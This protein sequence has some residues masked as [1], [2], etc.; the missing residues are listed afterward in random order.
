MLKRR[1]L[2]LI[3]AVVLVFSVSV[4]AFAAV[5]PAETAEDTDGPAGPT[6]AELRELFPNVQLGDDGYIVTNTPA[7]VAEDELP[8]SV[9]AAGDPVVTYTASEE[10]GDTC[11]LAIYSDGSYSAYGLTSI[12][13]GTA[14]YTTVTGGAKIYWNNFSVYYSMS[15]IIYYTTSTSGLTTISKMTDPTVSYIG[16]PLNPHPASM[17]VISRQIV[18]STQ[19]NSSIPAVATAKVLLTI[20]YAAF[21]NM[22]L[23]A[24]VYNGTPQVVATTETPT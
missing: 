12:T 14:D 22:V 17:S 1:I 9:V 10:N 19:T 6:I 16:E 4:P 7:A 23:T 3:L 20:E 21:C 5:V 2:S 18:R 24:N 11:T 8:Q 15:Y 13:N